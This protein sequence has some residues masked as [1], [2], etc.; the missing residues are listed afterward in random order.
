[1]ASLSR[2]TIML[3]AI[4]FVRAWPNYLLHHGCAKGLELLVSGEPPPIMGAIPILDPTILSL[5]HENGSEVGIGMHI[6]ID[7]SLL[8]TH[9]GSKGPHGFQTVFVVSSGALDGGLPC[10]DSGA[11][12]VC[13]SCGSGWL[14][15][16]RWTATRS[17]SA[18]IAI[19]AA[20]A[21]FGTPAV[22]I[23]SRIVNV[24]PRR[25]SVAPAPGPLHKQHMVASVDV[26]GRTYANR[27]WPISFL[28]A[29]S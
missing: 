11:Q 1:M 16:V 20:R 10:G 4:F 5:S 15:H 21:G 28:S 25:S 22:T 26:A 19:G 2:A 23:A 8:L 14:R 29:S 3:A 18:T 12:L 9:N 6:S 17:G 13:T 7:T 27:M 24:D